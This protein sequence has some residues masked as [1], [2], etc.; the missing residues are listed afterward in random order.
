MC[1]VLLVFCV[2]LIRL[3]CTDICG[4]VLGDFIVVLARYFPASKMRF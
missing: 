1:V 4:D 3:K 2:V